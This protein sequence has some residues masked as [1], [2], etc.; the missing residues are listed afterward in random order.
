TDGG[1]RI[2][3]LGPRAVSLG[4]SEY[5]WMRHGVVGGELAPLDL[6]LEAR[7]QAATRAAVQVGLA[8]ACHDC[9]DGGIAVAL[10]EGCVSGPARVGCRVVL[11]GPERRDL[12]LFGEGPS[13]IL[14]EVEGGRQGAFEA[15]MGEWAI[16]WSWIGDTG[17]ARLTVTLGGKTVVDAD[18][19]RLG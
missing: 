10:A 4:G 16:P 1:R 11:D 3:L 17:G 6:A 12:A 2:A 13:R 8:S 18:L 15:L 19:E 14:V 7:I 5:L 9:S